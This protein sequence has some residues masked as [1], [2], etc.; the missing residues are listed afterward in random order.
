MKLWLFVLATA[1]F[2]LGCK[3]DKE[4]VSS[5][6]AIN[7]HMMENIDSNTSKRTLIFKCATEKIYECS[8]YSIQTSVAMAGDIITIHFEKIV[9]PDVCL[10][11][12]A[13]ASAY[14]DL[15]TLPNKTYQLV[16]SAGDVTI[17]GQLTVSTGSYKADIPVQHEIRIVDAD[18]QRIPVN[19]IYGTI[20]Y[21]S[22]SFVPV[23]QSFIDSL[24]VIGAVPATYSPGDYYTFTI[25][26]DGQ[27]EQ[28]QLSGYYFTR[29]FI[30]NYDGSSEMV[31]ALVG[32]YGVTH[33]DLTIT[34]NTSKGQIFYSW[35]R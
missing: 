24:Q 1:L 8:N 2:T 10:T 13:P 5:P 31:Q 14:I 11:S 35:L 16:L 26:P 15:G 22:E 25:Q 7:I 30:F 27:I 4:I 19:V 34:L 6:G 21:P 28:T 12:P 18:L 20:G 17:E 9:T 3:K 29:S 33:P 23:V 32:K